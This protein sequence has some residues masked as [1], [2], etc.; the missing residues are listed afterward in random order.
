MEA[1][2][3]RHEGLIAEFTLAP[4]TI[5]GIRYVRVTRRSQIGGLPAIAAGRCKAGT[6]N[7]ILGGQSIPFFG[8]AVVIR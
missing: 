6:D 5:D 4:E 1:A 2:N 8:D 3:R 7:N